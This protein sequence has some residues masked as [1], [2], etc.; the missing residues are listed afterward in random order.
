VTLKLTPGLKRWLE[1]IAGDPER[2][3]MLVQI[4]ASG[5]RA[6]SQLQAL[7]NAGYVEYCEDPENSTAPE[8]VRLTAAGQKALTAAAKEPIR[9]RRDGDRYIV[10]IGDDRI[11]FVRNAP[12][13]RRWNAVDTT[14]VYIRWFDT[15]DAAGK[16]L[17][18][19]FTKIM[20]DGGL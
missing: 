16:A 11:G 6:S 4:T 8:R 9:Y 3:R 1:F 12:S 13:R 10:H 15:R 2:G 5:G 7:R 20:R 17:H 19:R 14:M 18:R